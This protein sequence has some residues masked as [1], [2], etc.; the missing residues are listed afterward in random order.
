MYRDL[1]IF[2]LRDLL[3]LNNYQFVKAIITGYL[4]QNSSQYFNEMR[5][6]YNYNARGSKERMIFKITR[7]TTRYGLKPLHH[8][9]VNDWN[10]LLKNIGPDRI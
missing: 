5:N 1:K 3:T 4:P 2:R 8:R 6:Q 9:A 10:K 7:K